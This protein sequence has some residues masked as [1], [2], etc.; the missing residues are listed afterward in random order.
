MS[1]V[2]S[3]LEGQQFGQL[4]AIA[5]TAKRNHNKTIMWLC[6][7]LSCGQ[8]TTVSSTKLKAGEIKSCGC[9]ETIKSA[10]SLPGESGFNTLFSHYKQSARSRN[11][12]F[13]LTIGEFRS[14]VSGYCNYCEIS[15]S[16]VTYGSQG[17]KREYGKFI[18][19]GIDRVDSSL[20]YIESNCVTCCK[21]CNIAKS[22]LTTREFLAWIKRAYNFTNA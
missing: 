20:G 15:P 7:C 13:E 21:T 16:R 12:S 22:D 4:L 17:A 8:E 18:S 1:Q 19:N 9:Q 14:L 5:P 2:A 11:I 10:R 3:K 6:K